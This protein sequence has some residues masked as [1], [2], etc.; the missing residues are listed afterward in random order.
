MIMLGDTNSNPL[1]RW[2]VNS[3]L[4]LLLTLNGED[5]TKLRTRGRFALYFCQH[6]SSSPLLVSSSSLYLCWFGSFLL[7]LL[8]LLLHNCWSPQTFIT[9]FDFSFFFHFDSVNQFKFFFA[10]FFLVKNIKKMFVTRRGRTESLNFETCGNLTKL[11]HSQ[12]GLGVRWIFFVKTF[13]FFVWN[14]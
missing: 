6:W 10:L 1:A 13:A 12:T 14:K 9:L 7:L 4:C 2:L 11:R 3:V 8:L 5:Y